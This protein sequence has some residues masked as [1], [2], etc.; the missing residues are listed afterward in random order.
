MRPSRTAASSST[1]KISCLEG[2]DIGNLP[3][4]PHHLWGMVSLRILTSS[5]SPCLSKRAQPIKFLGL[6]L[7][8]LE[9]GFAPADHMTAFR[10]LNC[11]VAELF[12]SSLDR[13]QTTFQPRRVSGSAVIA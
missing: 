12:E 1:T 4:L 6:T 8:G 11:V 3:S 2:L 5:S 9:F 13:F 7:L 10:A